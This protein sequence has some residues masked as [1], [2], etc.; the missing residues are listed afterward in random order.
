MKLHTHRKIIYN[1]GKRKTRTYENLGDLTAFCKLV[2][3][4]SNRLKRWDDEKNGTKTKWLLQ[5]V[6]LLNNK[7]KQKVK[8]AE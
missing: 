8:K 4:N 3:L 1:R 2:R 6:I 7:W 5:S